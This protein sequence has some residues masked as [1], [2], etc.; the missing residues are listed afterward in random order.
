VRLLK[1]LRL[2]RTCKLSVHDISRTELDE[3]YGL[4]RFNMPF[5]LGLFLGLRYS[6]L[7]SQAKKQCRILDRDPHRFQKY[8]SDIAGQDIRAHNDSVVDAIGCI[9]DWLRAS[10][11]QAGIPGANELVRRFNAFQQDLPELCAGARLVPTK[12][13]FVDY[14]DLVSQWLRQV[15]IDLTEH[16]LSRNLR[17]IPAGQSRAPHDIGTL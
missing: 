2:I 4:P 7:P 15:P 8:L 14:C 17:S 3:H 9:R 16:L 11:K 13:I 5:E 10:S 12:L 1:I 6:G